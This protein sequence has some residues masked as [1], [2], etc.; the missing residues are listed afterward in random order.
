[1]LFR[2]EGQKG[3]QAPRVLG[4]AP[5]GPSTS[6][7]PLS[8]VPLSHLRPHRLPPLAGLPPALRSPSCPPSGAAR[9][10]LP[11]MAPHCPK[12]PSRRFSGLAF[13]GP[14]LYSWPCPSNISPPFT[15]T[16]RVST[17]AFFFFFK[18]LFER[19][20][21]SAWEGQRERERE[22]IPSRLHAQCRARSGAN[23]HEP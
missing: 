2:S 18:F 12:N 8:S 1:M 5:E 11:P 6:T 13:Q 9:E 10:I 4:P 3:L 17:F 19:E 14:R 21:A 15:P 7:L 20:R 23:S 16:P 22:R